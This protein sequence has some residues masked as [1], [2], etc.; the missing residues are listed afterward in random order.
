MRRKDFIKTCGVACL[1]GAAMLTLLE[2]CAA[3]HHY[4]KPAVKDGKLSIR[5][6]EFL[7]VQKE[8]TVQRQYVLVR[9]DRLNSPICIFRL[10][11]DRY[12]ALLMKCTHKGCELRPNG[13]FL[14]CPCHGSEFTNEGKVQNP[15]A[16]KDLQKFKVTTDH[17]NIYIQI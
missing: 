2:S 7:H 6:S 5:K 9:D 16:E 12:S 1:S 15:P 8:K 17:E 13:D 14:A 11:E 4:A 10:E 3:S